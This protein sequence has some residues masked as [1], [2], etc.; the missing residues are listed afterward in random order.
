MALTD[1][2]MKIQEK[3]FTSRNTLMVTEKPLGCSR[4]AG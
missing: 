2:E 4:G 1:E 3:Y